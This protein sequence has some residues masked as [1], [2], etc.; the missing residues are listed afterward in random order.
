MT[1]DDDLFDG[2]EDVDGIEDLTA[3]P[4]AG[5]GNQ[6]H[7]FDPDGRPMTAGAI[8]REFIAGITYDEAHA[9][10]IGFAPWFL[11]V[12]SGHPALLAASMAITMGALGLWRV[13]TRPLRFTLREPHWCLGGAALGWVAGGSTLGWL[14]AGKAVVSV[15]SPVDPALLVMA[16]APLLGVL[17]AAV[18]ALSLRWWW[19]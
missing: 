10:I 11:F 3:Q 19:R 16:S 18:A 9:A 15:L 17:L 2:I 14:R 13:P 7:P 8:A 4:P 12:V 6:G 5:E 1:G